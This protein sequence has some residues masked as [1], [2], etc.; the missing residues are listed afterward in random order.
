MRGER[1]EVEGKPEHEGGPDPW[2]VAK[3]TVYRNTGF[4]R[5]VVICVGF[6]NC[7]RAEASLTST[8]I[9]SLSGGGTDGARR[10]SIAPLLGERRGEGGMDVKSIARTS[11]SPPRGTDWARGGKMD[12]TVLLGDGVGIVDEARL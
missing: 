5:G 4:A 8:S 3:L 12:D 10:I 1:G 7:R 9:R 2:G 11:S 6:V